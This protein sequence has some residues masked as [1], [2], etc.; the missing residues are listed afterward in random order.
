MSQNIFCLVMAGGRGT[1]FW[2]ESTSKKPKQY[3]SLTSDKSLLT[4]T[5]ERFEGLV[6]EDKRYVVT[7]KEQAALAEESL[8]SSSN[9]KGIIF[10]P[11]GRNT[12]P[13]ILLS[14]AELLASGASEDDIVIIV[15]SDHVILN[16]KGFQNTLKKASD[17]AS[18]EDVIV[19]IGVTPN[20]P[21]TGFGYIHRGEDK[22]NEV[23]N[24]SQFKEKPN[25]DIAKEYV[26]SGEYYWNAGMFL[27]RLGVLASQ[28]KAHAPEMYEHFDA[29][30]G[31]TGKEAEVAEIYSKIPKDSIDYAILE[32]SKDVLVVP[33]EFDWNDLGSWD[34]LEAVCEKTQDN[35]LVSSK[36]HHF[37]N[38]KG[39]IVFAPG[40]FVSLTNV[41]DL[42]IVSNEKTLLVLPKT[43]SQKVKEVVEALKGTEFEKD[44]L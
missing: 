19:T 36:G 34:A 35:T 16:T 9:K 2:P 24:V 3:L 23:F 8:V 27:G 5:L 29:L 42:V 20:F 10:E 25:A 37:S 13:C 11:S 15:P 44:L 7:V 4:E 21:H 39:N 12:G 33:A 32:K 31:A 1:R 22:G 38:A 40:K 43:D 6:S 28:F 41:D 30:K 14:I 17:V 18:K 26:A